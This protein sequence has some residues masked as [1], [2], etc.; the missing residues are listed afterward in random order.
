VAVTCEVQVGQYTVRG[1][2]LGGVQTCFQIPQFNLLFDIG[3]CPR[4]FAGT[5]RLFIT[6]GHA[7]H[8][9]GLISILSIRL[10]LGLKDP[11]KVFA[12]DYMVEGLKNAVKAYES[13][14]S[15]P[16]LWDI[17][18]MA[19]GMEIPIN[20][21][22]FIRAFKSEHVIETL[23]YTAWERVSKLKSE[24]KD[25]P[26]PEIGIRKHRG[27]D[28]FDVIERPLLSF[29]GD[30]SIA[31]LEQNP[32]LFESRVLLLE[33][34][35][36]DDRK[37]ADM[38]TQHGHIHLDQ[39]LKLAKKFQNEHLVFTHFSQSY[40]PAEVHA[41]IKERCADLFAP[42]IHPFAP[43]KGTWPG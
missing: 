3:H 23:G 25:L 39:V 15:A 32:H 29:P 17:Q 38:C 31:T 13:F 19:P 18:S 8:A 36:I 35:Y 2:S 30:T 37:S 43:K 11:L 40:R 10:L 24:F 5:E 21:R 33:S 16:Y 42:Q 28:L 9:G 1:I 26:G 41:I 4:S 20:Q 14:Q 12:P 27:D 22:V 6:H 34:T 7:D